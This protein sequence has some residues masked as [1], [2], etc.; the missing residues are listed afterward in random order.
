M[1]G[2]ELEEIRNGTEMEALRS[3]PRQ[4]GMGL[5]NGQWHLERT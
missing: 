3:V 1:D 5:T 4:E 2:T